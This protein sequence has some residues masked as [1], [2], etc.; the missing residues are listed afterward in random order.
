MGDSPLVL[1][2]GDLS[3]YY[4]VEITEDPQPPTGLSGLN[5]LI[6]APSVTPVPEPSTV[7][8]LA[9]GAVTLLA[10]SRSQRRNS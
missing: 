4:P 9:L 8:L 5:T 10:R 7:A 2:G 3:L 6:L 1:R